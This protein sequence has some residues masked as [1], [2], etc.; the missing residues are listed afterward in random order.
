M[1][2]Y[3]LEAVTVSGDGD[4]VRITFRCVEPVVTVETDENPTLPTPAEKPFWTLDEILR[5]GKQVNPPA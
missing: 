1:D 3:R 5:V 2:R 4:N